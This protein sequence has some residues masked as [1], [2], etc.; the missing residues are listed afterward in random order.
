MIPWR[1]YPFIRLLCPFIAGI[2]VALRLPVIWHTHP[3]VPVALFIVCLIL[4]SHSKL[5]SAYNTRWV[6]GLA[7]NLLILI[8]AIELTFQK[9]PLCDPFHFS[10]FL[11][12]NDQVIFGM[13]LEPVKVKPKTA[14]IVLRISGIVNNDSLIETTGRTI[15]YLEKDSNALG[16]K[17]GDLIIASAILKLVEGPRNPGEFDYKRYL[18][19]TGIYHQSYIM[20]GKWRKLDSG[21][22]NLLVALA[23]KTRDHLIQILADC[24]ISGEELAVMSALVLGSTDMIDRELMRSYSAAGVIHI[25]SVSGLHV[26]MVYLVFDFLLSFLK[27]ARYGTTIKNILVILGIWAYAMITGMSPP[28]LRA[29]AMITLLVTGSSLNRHTN[30]YNT[31]AASAFF[32]LLI[33]PY[34]ITQIGFQLSYLALTGIVA[35]Q[36]PIQKLWS[37]GPWLIEKIWSLIAVS[38]AAQLATFPMA[39]YYFNQFPVFFL[40][41]NLLVIPLSAWIIYGAIIIWITSFSHVVSSILAIIVNWLTH[42]MNLIVRTVENIPGAVARNL[43]LHVSEVFL[44]YAMIVSIFIFFEKRKKKSGIIFLFSAILLLS[45]SIISKIDEVKQRKLIVYD[46]DTT[47]KMELYSN[48]AGY[49]FDS[50]AELNDTSG[51]DY[52]FQNSRRMSGIRDVR[53]FDID[54]T[55]RIKLP[56]LFKQDHFIQF[57]DRRIVLINKTIDRTNSGK[58]IM[59]DYIIISDDPEVSIEDLKKQFQFREIIIAPSCD[60]WKSEKWAKQCDRLEIPCHSIA[61]EGAFV[62]VW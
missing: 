30:I 24:G 38:I 52:R 14:G 6:F 35:F 48:R 18:S 62:D 25:L 31:L 43:V 13:V 57:L 2:L 55:R 11:N 17:Y 42:F 16:L 20:S 26:G 50:H 34:F 54:T 7:V 28:V 45:F 1:S 21:R 9:T 41:T 19:K 40:L 61:R 56:Q 49:F 44:I 4:V 59:V 32:L 39:T 5:K 60:R 46:I 29:S 33:N 27:R 36:E 10:K 51:L 15:L 53:V 23:L 58:P 8:T 22:G 37:P 47:L 12:R 3:V